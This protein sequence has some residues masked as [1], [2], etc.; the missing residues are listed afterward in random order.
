MYSKLIVW[1][2]T[3]VFEGSAL[4]W[5]T[6]LTD[7]STHTS[8]DSNFPPIGSHHPIWNPSM[9]FHHIKGLL[10]W[11]NLQHRKF[12]NRNFWLQREWC[13]HH[14]QQLK[15]N[16]TR[17]L[18]LWSTKMCT[19]VPP[20]CW[21]SITRIEP[22]CK[23]CCHP[24]CWDVGWLKMDGCVDRWQFPRFCTLSAQ[25]TELNTVW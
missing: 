2:A 14:K 1:K 11:K 15:E 20:Q 13:P 12:L 24:G 23:Y 7:T 21:L 19:L 8:T 4:C 5:E 3:L 16:K 6:A 17:F 10:I 25:S 22:L 9:R 18:P